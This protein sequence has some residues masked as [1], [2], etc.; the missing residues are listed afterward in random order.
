MQYTEYQ[1]I[2]VDDIS[3]C[4][5]SMGVQHILFFGSGMSQRYFNAP[6]WDGL[7]EIL[8]QKCPKIDKS[9]AYY[10]Q[11]LQN[12][13]AIGT[14]FSEYIREWAWEKPAQFPT[15]LFE[16]TQPAN[17]YIKYIVAN[18]FKDTCGSGTSAVV[19]EQ[20]GRQELLKTGVRGKNGQYIKFSRIGPM[21]GTTYI[22]AEGE[23][24][25][26]DAGAN[27][28]AEQPAHWKPQKV[29]ICFGPEQPRW[30]NGR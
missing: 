4:L 8:T 20:W 28:V 30:S 12:P 13:I 29:L 10:K 14:E 7:L 19:A 1:N 21:S 2:I 11:K 24:T 5:D 26:S 23:T 18:I 15:E 9:I 22:Q 27:S 17:I 25:W 6:T 3:T 16:P